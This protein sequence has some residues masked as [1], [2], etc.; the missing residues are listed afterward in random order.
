MQ[1]L[2]LVSCHVFEISFINNSLF[3]LVVVVS[4]FLLP[5]S[6]PVYECRLM[7]LL[8]SFDTFGFFPVLGDMNQSALVYR[9]L[10]EPNFSF[11]LGKSLGME[12]LCVLW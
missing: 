10:Y 6:V 1:P 11:L 4:F 3:S 5:S 9:F 12:L 7:Y 8:S 2:R